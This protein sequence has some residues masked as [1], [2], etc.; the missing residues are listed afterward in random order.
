MSSLLEDRSACDIVSSY[1]G[2]FAATIALMLAPERLVFGGGVMAGGALLPDIRRHA[3]AQL[4]GYV[5][6]QLLTGGLEQF[7]VSPQLGER[8]GVCGAILLAAHGQ[9]V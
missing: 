2:Q 4:A 8:S 3:R 7:I 1:L 5:T 9:A 6:H